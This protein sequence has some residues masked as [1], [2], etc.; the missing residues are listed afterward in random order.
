MT[1]AY[2]LGVKLP[3]VAHKLA[4]GS[5]RVSKTILWQ[6][7]LST[8]RLRK[9]SGKEKST[10]RYQLCLPTITPLRDLIS[11]IVP[12]EGNDQ[13]FPEVLDTERVAPLLEKKAMVSH[14]IAITV[15]AVLHNRQLAISEL[16][17]SKKQKKADIDGLPETLMLKTL[18]SE[19]KVMS[20]LNDFMIDQKEQALCVYELIMYIS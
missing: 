3:K 4:T 13:C 9:I 2:W 14:N 7:L 15:S 16:K 11:L 20:Q 17:S 6:S 8:N 10:D 19:L 1:P 5:Q 12:D 18:Q